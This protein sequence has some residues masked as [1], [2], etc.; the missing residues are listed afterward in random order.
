MKTEVRALRDELTASATPRAQMLDALQHKPEA[1]RQRRGRMLRLV[2]IGGTAYDHP[3]A[4]ASRERYEEIRRWWSDMRQRMSQRSDESNPVGELTR[5]D[6]SASSG[7]STPPA[8][9]CPPSAGSAAPTR[10]GERRPCD[11]CATASVRG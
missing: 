6:G 4:K 9:S 3:G 7:S 2:V 11:A 8:R 1:R 10:V 5:S